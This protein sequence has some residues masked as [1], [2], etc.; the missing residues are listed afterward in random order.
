MKHV[1]TRL[2]R[3]QVRRDFLWDY[4][5]LVIILALV[6]CALMAVGVIEIAGLGR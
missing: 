3:P 5:R 1:L 2:N 6:V 4:Y